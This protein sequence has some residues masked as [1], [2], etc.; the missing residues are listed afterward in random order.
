MV[1]LAE[2]FTS[3]IEEKK[4]SITEDEVNKDI[5]SIVQS[6]FVVM[7]ILLSHHCDHSCMYRKDFIILRSK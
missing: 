4:G 7:F 6:L 5:C 1:A 2:K 3:K